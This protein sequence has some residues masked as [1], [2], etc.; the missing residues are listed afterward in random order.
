[1]MKI[2]SSPGHP[3]TGC[4]E[5]P[6][7]K[8]ISHRAALFAA[9][10]HGESIFKNFLVAGVTNTMLQALS[11][12]GIEWD[13]NQNNLTVKGQGV[14]SWH[15]PDQQLHC[16]NSATT[17]RLLAGALAATGTAAQL[18]GSSGLRQR[19]MQRVVIPLQKMAVPIIASEGGKAPLIL[20]YRPLEHHL[21]AIEFSMP[22]A[23]AQ[24]KT[25]IMLAAL[26]AEGM[27]IIREPGPSRDHSERMLAS[28]GARIS[29]I[30]KDPLVTTIISPLAG[31]ALLP[32]QMSIPG[33][34][35]SAA[36]LLVAAS[37]TPGSKIKLCN[38]GLNPTRTGL[39]DAMIAMGAQI[40]ISNL[41]EEQGE[42]VGDLIIEYG[43]LKA[44]EVNGPMV[45]RMI[46]EFPVFAIAAASAEGVT[47]VRQAA[48]LRNKESDRITV[49]CRN[50]RELGVQVEELP[51][52][53]VIQG[54]SRLFGGTINAHG[55]H[56]MAMAFAVAGLSAYSPIYINGAEMIAESFPGFVDSL[57]SL[58]ADV[59]M[60]A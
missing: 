46:D 31:Q 1:M 34:F 38:V 24:V 5:L 25:A 53:F 30:S 42:P 41:V 48:E 15:T 8:S 44:I 21:K 12:L 32:L 17:M 43:P 37:I 3:L 7:D 22:V 27:T 35:S 6:G 52:G 50:L 39:L 13:L 57:R 45:V 20:S 51:D 18:D 59:S 19:P 47:T 54:G 4:L 26:V 33:D 60:D 40:H 28:M 58:G 2:I 23:S 29:S 56:R 36:F 49:L 11:D 16:G 55:D 9:L 10:A 14:A